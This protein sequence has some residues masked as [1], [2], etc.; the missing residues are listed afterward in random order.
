MSDQDWRRARRF[1]AWGAFGLIVLIGISIIASLLF[2]GLRTS[3]VYYPFFPAFLFP[4]HFGWLGAIFIILVVFLMA[5]WIFLP[6]RNGNL[7][8]SYSQ[9]RDNGNAQ[10]IIK[11]RYAKGEITKE[12]FEQMMLDLKRAD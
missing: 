2:F 11:E 7:S 5:R 10:Y 3:G 1:V 12:E 8:G 6:W 9:N 4:F